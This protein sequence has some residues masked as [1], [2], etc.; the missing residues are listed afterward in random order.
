[1]ANLGER[2]A[3]VMAHPDDEVLWAGSM[4]RTAE[5]IVLVFGELTDGPQLTAGRREAMAAFPLP[6]LDWLEMVEAGSFD[7]ASWRH[8]KE[9][10]YGLYLHKS[11]KLMWC[12]DPARYR[13]QFCEL[14]GRLRVSLAGM[15][16]VIV[17]GPWGEYGHED[18]V[19]VFRAV[20]GLAK[21][22]G[23]KVW[24]PAYVAPKSEMLMRRNLRFFG[25]PTDAFPI[26]PALT[27]E[28]AQ[29][30]KRTGTWTWFDSY[31]WPESERF[32]PWRPE[33]GGEIATEADIQRIALPPEY[34]ATRRA[35]L[36]WKRE[37]K[38]K[39]LSWM[40]RRSAG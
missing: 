14:Q 26:D 22:M 7:S 12:F 28:I 29:I 32:L 20:S 1:M 8:P 16:N 37:V 15:K 11:L 13:A 23:F 4:L 31:V 9:T 30:Y 34:E 27:D 40:N 6:G 17:H 38:R 3:I 10:E 39:V 2:L 36:R 24:V 35:Q 33:G 25:R 5:K 19:Q 21:E 18:H